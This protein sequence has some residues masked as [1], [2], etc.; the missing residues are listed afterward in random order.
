M[1]HGGVAAEHEA[2]A[3]FA[4]REL[5]CLAETAVAQAFRQPE[6]QPFAVSFAR[7]DGHKTQFVVIL[8]HQRMLGK[9]GDVVVKNQIVVVRYAVGKGK[10]VKALPDF[11]LLDN[12]KK[13]GDAR[14]CAQHNQIVAVGKTLGQEKA[15]RG[16]VQQDAVACLHG[17]EFGGHFAIG[18]QDGEEFQRVG[19]FG[20]G[21]GVG[22]PNVA[23]VL[24]KAEAGEL[25]C[26]EAVAFGAGGGKGDVG[27]AVVFYPEDLFAGVFV[28]LHD[29]G[30]GGGI[31]SL[32]VGW[33]VFRLP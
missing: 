14:A 19:V 16:F 26:G 12:G 22:A 29:V 13:R 23:C 27:G 10:R 21:D 25:P 11:R 4:E 28:F 18:N 6:M 5:E 8:A 31:G 2:A 7:G 30:F 20:G 33:R 24:G 32:K 15:L 9:L 17:G 1:H 3:F